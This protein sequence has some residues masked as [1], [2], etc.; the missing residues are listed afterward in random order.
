MQPVQNW[1]AGMDTSH[2]SRP[3]Y[4]CSES[5]QSIARDNQPTHAGQSLWTVYLHG[6]YPIGI[7]R[8]SEFA[9]TVWVIAITHLKGL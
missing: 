2:P 1:I 8:F 7:V 6:L 9:N 4:F 3:K 5:G